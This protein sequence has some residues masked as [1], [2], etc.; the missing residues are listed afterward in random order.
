MNRTSLAL[1]SLLATLGSA[2]VAAGL[3]QAGGTISDRNRPAGCVASRRG[4]SGDGR[5]AQRI[6]S[7]VVPM[8]FVGD[9]L[10]KWL[11]SPAWR[12]IDV[13]RHLGT[14]L[15]VP[16]MPAA[17]PAPAAKKAGNA[18]APAK[19]KVAADLVGKPAEP[20]AAKVQ[21]AITSR[22]TA[23]RPVARVDWQ[24]L[25]RLLK[26]VDTRASDDIHK[27]IAAND[28][29]RP[30]T[31]VNPV[32][33][34]AWLRIP[35][36]DVMFPSLPWTLSAHIEAEAGHVFDAPISGVSTRI[37]LDTL[38]RPAAAPV[39]VATPPAPRGG[40]TRKLP[41]VVDV[42]IRAWKQW[43]ATQLESAIGHTAEFGR[44]I[45]GNVARLAQQ[46]RQTLPRFLVERPA[47]V[48][49]AQLPKNE[50]K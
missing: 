28:G 4:T 27:F 33:R 22:A 19:I 44:W 3:D 5:D 31:D 35:Q 14:A 25:A 1:G 48:R 17:S 9:D 23:P 41:Q 47:A 2:L 26:T 46:V 37:A 36:V 7:A 29:L 39:R 38:G 8:S 20:V 49:N 15:V 13:T 16:R 40:K 50:V 18:D 12:S 6:G 21:P 32:R 30:A 10:Q 24:E 45:D 43:I 11:T 42:Q 34:Q